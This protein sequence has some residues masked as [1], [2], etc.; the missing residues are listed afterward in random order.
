L[1]SAVAGAAASAEE[2]LRAAS[3]RIP[4][5][6]LMDIRLRGSMD[7][8]EAARLL[9]DQ[10]RVP[11]VFLTAHVDDKT[12]ARAAETEP[13]GYVVK[14]FT[15]REGRGRIEMPLKKHAGEARRAERE[16]WFSAVLFSLAEAV[17]AC[18][19]RL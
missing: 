8:I 10:F 2:A 4:D 14:P 9:R 7:G 6:V 16:R 13:Y 18:D 17:L 3:D 5:L 1:G 12:V 11:V 15:P 19:E